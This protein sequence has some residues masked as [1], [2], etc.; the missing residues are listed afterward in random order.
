[1]ASRLP[2]RALSHRPIPHQP[3][4][5][6]P[7]RP[8]HRPTPQAQARFAVPNMLPR[9]LSQPYV[10]S[11]LVILQ[12]VKVPKTC[13]HISIRNVIASTGHLQ[14]SC[15]SAPVPEADKTSHSASPYIETAYSTIVK[16]YTTE[17]PAT[18]VVYVTYTTTT[19]KE[20]P[21]SKT[22]Y[23]PFTTETCLTKTYETQYYC[24]ATTYSISKSYS[25]SVTDVSYVTS[26][27]ETDTYTTTSYKPG[28][29]QKLA[30]M[31][32]N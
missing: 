32:E 25:T 17:K 12:V 18:T 29:L 1:V 28:K 22:E 30:E 21:A 31:N 3:T 9:C 19:L 4:R 7:T 2:F 13:V 11:Y 20:S 10:S 8:P 16:T 26:K 6:R 15:S 27:P 23:N 5:P 14:V 24:P